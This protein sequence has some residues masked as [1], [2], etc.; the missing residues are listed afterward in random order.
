VLVGS[1]LLVAGPAGAADNGTGD[2]HGLIASAAIQPFWSLGADNTLIEVTSP[3][4]D[5]VLH[6]LYFD[7]TCTKIKSTFKYVSY[8]GA[9]MWSPDNDGIDVTGLAVISSNKNNISA[10]PIRD[11]EAIHVIGHWIN[12]AL[13]FVRVVD[14]IAVNLPETGRKFSGDRQHFSPLRSAASFGAP[15]EAP[16]TPPGSPFSTTIY[17]ICP[18][19]NILGPTGVLSPKAGFGVAPRIAYLPAKVGGEGFIFAILYDGDEQPRADY[20]LECNCSTMFELDQLASGAYTKAAVT[21]PEL[22]TYTEL[23]TY[24]VPLY[25]DPPAEAYNPRTFTG[26]RAIAVSSVAPGPV[27]AADSFGR[28]HNG[29]AYNYLVNGLDPSTGGFDPFDP[30]P[31]FVPGLR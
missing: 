17:V 28:L 26:Y 6:I 27:F 10:S 8:K 30:P 12:L 9:I 11:H 25:A 15:I 31:F 4:D 2:T 23:F 5:N 13:D 22:V 24:F 1:A 20:S 21:G 14:P 16:S 19:P 18:G 7:S 3:L 29:S